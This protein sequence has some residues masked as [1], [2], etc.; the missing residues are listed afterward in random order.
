M[1]EISAAAVEL[2]EWLS[3]RGITHFFIG[4]IAA[5]HW[6][7]ARQTGDVELCAIVPAEGEADFVADV[8][9]HFVSRMDDPAEFARQARMLMVVSSSG[10]PVDIALAG[11]GFEEQAAAHTFDLEVLPGKSIPICSAEDLVIY[12]A[13]AGRPKDVFDL[14]AIVGAQGPDLDV[15]R[16]RRLL[17]ML[18]QAIEDDEPLRLFNQAWQSYGPQTG[19]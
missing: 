3:S 6:G 11:T 16:V 13:L 18:C 19:N 4:G 9:G 17:R 15:R 5:Q 14:Q 2:H 7:E 8:L 10:C 12:K 1:D